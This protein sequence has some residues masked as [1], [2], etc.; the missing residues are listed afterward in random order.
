[1]RERDGAREREMNKYEK[2]MNVKSETN[3]DNV[4]IGKYVAP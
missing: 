2:N 1:M 4:R 3:L